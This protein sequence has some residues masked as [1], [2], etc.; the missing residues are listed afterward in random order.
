MVMQKKI[1]DLIL[2][3][4]AVI[5][6]NEDL[7][8]NYSSFFK[9]WSDISKL[10]QLKVEKLTKKIAEQET[11][12]KRTLE[13]KLTEIKNKD[14]TMA[15][16][17]AVGLA[18]KYDLHNDIIAILHFH[19]KNKYDIN[20]LYELLSDLKKISTTIKDAVAALGQAQ[21]SIMINKY[22]TLGL[23]SNSTFRAQQAA[24][25]K[26]Y[27]LNFY[28]K[29]IGSL[30]KNNYKWLTER[31]SAVLHIKN[32]SVNNITTADLTAKE[33]KQMHYG[34]LITRQN[35]LIS[36]LEN[37]SHE[38]SETIKA[39]RREISVCNA[40]FELMNQDMT[41][42]IRTVLD[43]I[44]NDYLQPGKSMFSEEERAQ[45]YYLSGLLGKKYSRQNIIF[46]RAF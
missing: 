11:R 14:T 46:F 39:N 44:K 12:Y 35:I 5:F 36:L 1:I 22:F 33:L 9:K 37:I 25:K 32:S 15:L 43:N 30:N 2:D 26:L 41:S 23:T 40:K 29:S 34:E 28:L 21:A 18:E 6:S 16:K 7:S 24:E 38:I 13:K 17:F 19:E 8:K 31:L 20:E 10:N 4:Q 27:D 45:F 3:K 42:V